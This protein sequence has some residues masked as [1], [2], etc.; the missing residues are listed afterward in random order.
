MDRVPSLILILR[1]SEERRVDVPRERPG[2]SLCLTDQSGSQLSSTIAVFP[3]VIAMFEEL[4]QLL[5]V[6]TA[7]GGEDRSA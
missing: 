7:V 6:I 5:V 4:S 2:I 1:L 3:A